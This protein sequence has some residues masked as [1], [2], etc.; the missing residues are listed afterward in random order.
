MSFDSLYK[1]YFILSPE[2]YK[3]IYLNRYQSESTLTFDCEINGNSAF[4]FFHNDINILLNQI[5]EM[6][7]RVK[8]AF[9]KLP[10]LA[11]QQFI[12]KTM[13][14]EIVYNNEI[15]GVIS[16]RKDIN[17]IIENVKVKDDKLNRL[18]GIVNKYV[19]L[20]NDVDLK[21]DNSKD[22]RKLYDESFLKEV[23]ANDSKNEPDGV[24]F[25]KGPV[26]VMSSDKEIHRGICP[27]SELIKFVDKSFDILH[28]KDIHP[29]IRLS[30][31]H[32]LFA[33]AHPFYDGNGRINRLIASY[34][35]SKKYSVLVGYNLSLMIKTN[36]T[37]YY[38]AFKHTNDV[39]NKGDI[40]T[41]VY[42]FLSIILRAFEKT[43]LFAMEYCYQLNKYFEIIADLKIS[44][45]AKDL[46]NVLVQ[47]EL[48]VEFGVSA[49]ELMV[50]LGFSVNT[51]KKYLS[52][53]KD[54]SILKE[55]YVFNKK[56]YGINLDKMS[57]LK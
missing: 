34:F 43:E 53:L 51:L 57:N 49:S 24:I 45:K 48:F 28:D 3:K 8:K 4:F 41:F 33:Y 42:E 21:I 7:E 35:I 31:F 36:L 1:M 39:R 20:L 54:L 5:D 52:E 23:I 13:I 6:G 38:D 25:R 16:T 37:K 2:D 11:R 15:E 30:I 14:D 32:Y 22:V 44:D 10:E 47:S 55:I 12:K 46:L 17:I 27:E 29:L 19:T 50:T 18:D 40:T 26:F 56:F 9:N